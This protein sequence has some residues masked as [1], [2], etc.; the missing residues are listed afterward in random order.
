MHS[1]IDF[2]NNYKEEKYF[3]VEAGHLSAAYI[4]RITG[5]TDSNPSKRDKR[6]NQ[7]LAE[8]RAQ[9]IADFLRSRRISGEI[10]IVGKPKA[11][12]E[13]YSDKDRSIKI[14]LIPKQ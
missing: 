13:P 1:F 12:G 7:G 6:G 10:K 3:G 5:G 2:F 14:E 4:I 8:D 9:G 11:T